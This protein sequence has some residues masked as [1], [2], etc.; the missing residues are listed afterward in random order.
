MRLRLYLVGLAACA[1][2]SG[3]GPGPGPVPVSV[4]LAERDYQSFRFWRDQLGITEDRGATMSLDGLSLDTLR[5][6]E[7]EKRTRLG[8]DLAR[9][10]SGTV[11]AGDT[12]AL[13]AMRQA[14]DDGL[15]RPPEESNPASDSLPECPA[16]DSAGLADSL[17]LERLTGQVLACYGA[18]A[19]R[20]VVDGDTLDRLSVLGQISRTADPGR[21]RRLFLALQPIWRSVNGND[22]TDS[23][24]RTMVGLRQAAWAAAGVSPIDRKGPAFGIPPD[25]LEAWLLGTLERWEQ[26][27]GDSL[28]EPWDW[29]F[30]YGAAARRFD[31]RLPGVRDILAVTDSFYR[32]LGADPALLRVHY[33][34]TPRIGKYPVAF[35]D[36][37][38]RPHRENGRWEPGEPWVFASYQ[39]GG[40]DNLAELLH[41]TGH[42]IH[43]A[44]IRTRPAFMDWPDNDT[45][46]E[47]LADVPA[48][49]LYEPAWQLR[50]LG[51]SM[52]LVRSLQA[53]YAWVMLDCAWGLFEIRIHRSP[54]RDPNRVWTDLTARYL[55][56]RPHPEWSWWALRGQLVDGP[57][58]LINYAL[59]AFLTADLRARL[60]ARCA[61]CI[62]GDRRYYETASASLYRFGLERPSRTVLEE[63]LGRPVRPQALWDD[64]SR[65]AGPGTAVPTRPSG[66]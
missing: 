43:I 4:P 23:P 37:G 31:R 8:S 44:A 30:R 18:A 55:H 61:G 10:R 49:Q 20:V 35:T 32:A 3:P 19:N 41:E 66:D 24:Y 9:I 53:R 51:D 7:A 33:D 48:V 17:R 45:F 6:R 42:A 25:S 54:T 58:Y 38:A 36:F 63:F 29:I 40:M 21:R 13:R 5:A 15:S 27:A 2:G 62:A 59:G 11:A 47:A 22:E 56:I 1:S 16:R 57:G 64:M 14:W 46:T 50:F 52:D 34:L 28:R 26:V 65:M 60:N 39:G 12:A